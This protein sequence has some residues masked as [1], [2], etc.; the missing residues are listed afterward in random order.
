MSSTL[1]GK[2]WCSIRQR[3]AEAE[4]WLT[5]AENDLA[6]AELGAGAGFFAQACFIC[7]QAA[8]KALKALHYLG[9]ARVVLGHSVVEL[10]DGLTANYSTL[11]RLREVAQQLDQ[12]YIPT[13]YPNGLPA[14]AIP[15]AVFTKRQADDAVAGA[16]AIIDS[17]RAAIRG[18]RQ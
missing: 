3:R 15:S 12:Y 2:A 8:E 14:G 13:R 6:F 16:R 7:Q 17:A 9:G 4:R 5:Q 10:L 1:F 18:Q 11:L